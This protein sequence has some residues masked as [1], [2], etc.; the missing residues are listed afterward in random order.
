MAN[1]KVRVCILSGGFN[2]RLEIFDKIKG[3]LKKCELHSYSKDTVAEYI[4][5]QVL[6]V[7]LFETTRL[8]A[9]D[10]I[11]SFGSGG[12]K[13]KK[14]LEEMI[15]SIPDGCVVAFNGIDKG[16]RNEWL[17]KIVNEIGKVYESPKYL[18][19]NS[20]VNH[21]EKAFKQQNKKHEDGCA[22]TLVSTIGE[23]YKKGVEVDKIYLSLKK[24]FSFVGD[25]GT[26]TKSD[27]MKTAVHDKEYLMFTLF[28]V[29]DKRDFIGCLSAYGKARDL[30][31]SEYESA[32]QVLSSIRWRYRLLMFLKESKVLG[33][34]DDRTLQNISEL[35]KLKRSGSGSYTIYELDKTED[36]EAKEKS[37]YTA[38]M[39]RNS[40][41]GN[42]SYEPSI[43]KY[44]QEEIHNILLSVNKSLF[45]IRSCYYS[46]A[47]IK[48]AVDNVLMTACS[49]LNTSILTSLRRSPHGV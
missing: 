9:L 22:E 2:F 20:A 46:D 25:N 1:D 7:N 37:Q 24:L 41:V 14:R 35:K 6:N 26:I 30:V 17:F 47:E 8:V 15:R 11:P 40:L 34:E 33:Y 19:K 3:F 29:M 27:V 44:S 48:L 39:A 18:Q 12:A 21:I 36:K 32:V 16:K 10:H 43:N 31:K 5:Q 38:G 28:D 4:E 42:Y 23:V 45:K 13:S 49:M